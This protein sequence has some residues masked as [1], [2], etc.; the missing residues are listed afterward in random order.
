MAKLMAGAKPIAGTSQLRGASPAPGEARTPQGCDEHGGRA[1]RVIA[2][3]CHSVIMVGTDLRGMGGI[4]AVVQGYIEGGV[5]ERIDCSYVATHRF[6]SRL[7]KAS[8]ALCGWVGAARRLRE[9]DAPLVHV[10]VSIGASFW[11]KSVICLLARLARRPYLLHVHGDF[12]GFY[13]ECPRAA[14]RLIR[15]VMARAALVLVVC[16]AWRVTLERIC[17]QARLEVLPNAVALPPPDDLARPADAPP[18][19]FFLGDVIPT[20]G[21]FDLARA[22]ARIARRFP[23]LKLVYAGA[24]ELEEVRR[25]ASRL[26]LA[27]R[28]ECVGW[29]DVPRKRAALAGATIFVLPSHLEGMPMSLLEAMA[30]GLPAIATSVGGVPE[31]IDHDVNGLLVPPADIDALAD[32]IARLMSEPG[33]RGRL[34]RA[35]RETIATRLA[36]GPTVERLLGIYRRF[37][38]E[39]RA[40]RAT[41]GGVDR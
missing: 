32:A 9:L 15:D 36:L 17:P 1:A 30:W 8:A 25:L 40:A 38:I 24:G 41:G 2:P 7:S 31:V 5:F 33:L 37:G 27:D 39:P 6:G 19:L 12:D 35:A 22:F 20:K 16:D 21:V 34:G 26:E 10:H 23:R 3:C 28:I 13:E 11:R 14:R 29:L 4:R 18:T